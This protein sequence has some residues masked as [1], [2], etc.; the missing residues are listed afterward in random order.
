MRCG[1]FLMI[2]TQKEKYAMK[3]VS[4]RVVAIRTAV[5]V[6]QGV[7]KVIGAPPESVGP[8]PGHTIPAYEAD[9]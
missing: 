2:R 9:E 3:Y 6:I 5:A 7:G 8:T 1:L 4:P